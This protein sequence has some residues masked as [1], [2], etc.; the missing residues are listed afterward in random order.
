M[1]YI[2]VAASPVHTSTNLGLLSCAGH[3]LPCSWSCE[4]NHTCMMISTNYCS[5][6]RRSYILRQRV[7]SII[8]KPLSLSRSQ[9]T[10]SFLPHFRPRLTFPRIFFMVDVRNSLDTSSLSLFLSNRLNFQIKTW[11][12]VRKVPKI[13]RFPDLALL[14]WFLIDSTVQKQERSTQLLNKYNSNSTC[15]KQTFPKV[16]KKI[17]KSSGLGLILEFLMEDSDTSGLFLTLMTR[18]AA[19]SFTTVLK[20]TQCHLA[21]ILPIYLLHSLQ[22]VWFRSLKW[23]MTLLK[24]CQQSS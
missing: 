9:S 21:K 14:R 23:L 5:G 13:W 16:K 3:K 11:L 24:H 18:Q 8:D 4:M 10:N 12:S 15:R 1:F 6:M 7:H 2:E 20:I 17:A 19:F 22:S